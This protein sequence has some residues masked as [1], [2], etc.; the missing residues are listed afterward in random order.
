MQYYVIICVQY[1]I[2]ICVYTQQNDYLLY[3]KN[4]YALM[5]YNFLRQYSMDTSHDNIPK[6][7][8]KLKNPLIFKTQEDCIS[9]SLQHEHFRQ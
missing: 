1:N 2:E 8:S 5:Q 6:F 7:A 4:T 3:Y 9:V